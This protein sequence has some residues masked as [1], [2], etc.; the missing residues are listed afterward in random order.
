MNPENR[1]G[2]KAETIP[3]YE[4]EERYAKLFPSNTGMPAKPLRM[5]LGS[6]IIQKQY[7]YSDKELLEQIRENLY[8]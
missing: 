8:Y 7:G 4:I 5:V 6:L 1:W 2:K 3:W